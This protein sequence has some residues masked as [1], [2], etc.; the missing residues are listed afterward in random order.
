MTLGSFL[1]ILQKVNGEH[2]WNEADDRKTPRNSK[3]HKES[4][5]KS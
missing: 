4:R 5:E 3:Y 2:P 1:K